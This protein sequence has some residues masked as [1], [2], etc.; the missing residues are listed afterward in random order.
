MVANNG[1]FIVC[2]SSSGG[3]DNLGQPIESQPINS[4]PI[5]C[6]IQ[7]VRDDKKG[8]YQDGKFIQRSYIIHIPF[9]RTFDHSDL[10]VFINEKSA[11]KFTI[12][13]I[14]HLSMVGRTKI[15]V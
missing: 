5:S 2:K 9:D 10:E 8:V 7:T 13:S 14:E 12:Q 6:H 11:G 1:Y 15:T 3:Y 4:M